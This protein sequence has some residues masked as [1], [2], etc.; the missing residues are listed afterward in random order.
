[1]SEMLTAAR[2][3]A[4]AA[5]NFALEKNALNHWK[6]MLSFAVKVKNNKAAISTMSKMRSLD[7]TVNFFMTVCGYHLDRFGQNFIEIVI[8]NKRLNLLSEILICFN[9]LL[10]IKENIVVI[11]ITSAE[12]LNDSQ[13][14]KI[15]NALEKRFLFRI[16]P[17]FKVS[18]SLIGGL[19]IHV[20]DSVIDGSIRSRIERL[21]NCLK[22]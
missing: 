3:Y 13:I 22:C 21:A 10:D 4:K 7:E 1:M 12:K 6:T 2:P 19:I 5:F 20:G 14:L 11:N 9:Q 16:K 15:T 18:K 17:N 8:R